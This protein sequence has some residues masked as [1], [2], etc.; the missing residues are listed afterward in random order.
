ME[1]HTFPED[2]DSLRPLLLIF[3]E[4][5]QTLECL[6]LLIHSRSIPS[7]LSSSSASCCEVI[8]NQILKAQFLFGL[9]LYLNKK[10]EFLT[11][12]TFVGPLLMQSHQIL[13]HRSI[14]QSTESLLRIAIFVQLGCRT[15]SKTLQI[16]TNPEEQFQCTFQQMLSIQQGPSMSSISL[17][18]SKLCLKYFDINEFL[19][20][21]YI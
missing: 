14:M 15:C 1:N 16:D 18:Y 3:C 11:M 12:I 2:S 10:Y 6:Y 13:R 5:V 17:I 20:E 4:E 19:R 7:L 8:K 21:L 9:Y